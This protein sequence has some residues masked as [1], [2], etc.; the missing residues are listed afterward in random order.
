MV[1]KGADRHTPASRT[2]YSPT[3]YRI[4][5][6]VH[7]DDDPLSCQ[8]CEEVQSHVQCRRRQNR[9][10]APHQFR[11]CS[12]HGLRARR[13]DEGAGSAGGQPRPGPQR[14]ARVLH[15]QIQRGGEVE[16]RHTRSFDSVH[17]IS[18]WAAA[19]SRCVLTDPSL[20]ATE[21]CA[22]QI[23]L[24]ATTALGRSNA[25]MAPPR[26]VCSRRMRCTDGIVES[27]GS[28]VRSTPVD[29]PVGVDVALDLRAPVA[30]PVAAGS[31]SVTSI[32][33]P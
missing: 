27:T 14:P 11:Q 16:H 30:R 9:A 15:P 10:L 17:S 1:G 29:G 24:A 12:G 7:K 22:L 21:P 20:C 31:W 23:F 4:H 5:L 32:Q 3:G 19:H 26:C 28:C 6:S 2:F 25:W 33:S 18:S 8:L 13:R